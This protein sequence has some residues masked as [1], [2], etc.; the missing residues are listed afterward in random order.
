MTEAAER[1]EDLPRFLV[2]RLISRDPDG[3]AA[4]YEENAVMAL[5]DG[6]VAVGRTAIGDAFRAFLASGPSIEPGSQARLLRN[7]ELAIT[8]TRLPDGTITVEVARQQTD[9]SWL[10]VID[11]PAL[12][13]G[14]DPIPRSAR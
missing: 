7:G 11:H 12:Y 4:L 14:L 8:S 13:T 3:L 9:G 10:W 6:N 2:E 1:P 5:P